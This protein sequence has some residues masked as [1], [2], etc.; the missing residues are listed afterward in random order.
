MKNAKPGITVIV[1][2]MLVL[3]SGY[4]RNASIVKKI[5]QCM[6]AAQMAICH[7]KNGKMSN[8]KMLI[9]GGVLSEQK[10]ASFSYASYIQLACT[11]SWLKE[12]NQMRAIFKKKN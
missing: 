3:G 1:S 6:L 5:S 2:L 12:L 8:G 11:V 9:C 4:A 7:Y 10:K